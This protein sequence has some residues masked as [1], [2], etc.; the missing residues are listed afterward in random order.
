MW[1][2]Y[3]TSFS[4]PQTP[5]MDLTI[6]LH[7]LL[8]NHNI[9]VLNLILENENVTSKLSENFVIGFCSWSVVDLGLICTYQFTQVSLITHVQFTGSNIENPKYK[10]I[11][12]KKYL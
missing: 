6:S 9:F 4:G 1:S 12:H 5:R 10:K 3:K 7:N 2:G 11:I 8:C